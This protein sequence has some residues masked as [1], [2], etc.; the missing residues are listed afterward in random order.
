MLLCLHLC[1]F[2]LLILHLPQVL[3]HQV[4]D[5]RSEQQ[6]APA[7]DPEQQKLL[8]EQRRRQEAV[9]HKD[10]VSRAAGGK[11]IPAS[12]LPDME[13]RDL[14]RGT[15]TSKRGGTKRPWSATPKEWRL[16]A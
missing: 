15:P 6:E 9:L 12:C 5:A 10:R 1:V 14:F 16:T 3:G 7:G 13:C 2:I 8:E 4:N 11:V